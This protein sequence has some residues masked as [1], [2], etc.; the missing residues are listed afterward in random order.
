MSDLVKKESLDWAIKSTNHYGDTDIFPTPFEYEAIKANWI[1]VQANLAVRDLASFSSSAPRIILM[2]KPDGTFRVAKQLDPFDSLLYSAIL[3]EM[4]P[5]IESYRVHSKIACSYRIDVQANGQIFQEENGWDNFHSRSKELAESG[6]FKYV[7]MLD[8]ADFYNQVSHHRIENALESANINRERAKNVEN[9]LGSITATFSKGVPVGPIPSIILAEICLDDVDKRLL[10][11]SISF[12]RYVDDFRIFCSSKGHALNILQDLTEYFYTSHRFSF[13]SNKTKIVDID[14]FTKREL[15]DPKEQEETLKVKNIN[16][17]IDIVSENLGYVITED[18]IS[19][20]TEAA[21]N[22]ENLNTLFKKCIVQK[23]LRLGFARYLL[24]R[25]TKLRIRDTYELILANLETL[26]PV[27]SEVCKYFEKTL[28][29]ES[30]DKV[31][32]VLYSFLSKNDY[33]KLPFVRMWVFDLLSKRPELFTFEEAL[34]LAE[35]SNETLGLR[36]TALIARAYNRIDWIRQY[37]ENWQC[38]D[39]WERRAIIWA[40]SVL[41]MDERRPWVGKLKDT[42]SDLLEKSVALKALTF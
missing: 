1:E 3:Y 9:F 17:F 36:P 24:R 33:G 4:A 13:Q 10:G 31:K 35:D 22:I 27:F 21:I 14:S 12:A 7:L 20:E 15:E 34:A 16:D 26:A 18:D 39:P 40:T 28:N 19:S 23:P 30:A 8:I 42:T 41:P 2:P 29:Q 6:K 25:A 5:N 32:P 37:K 11:K 38:H